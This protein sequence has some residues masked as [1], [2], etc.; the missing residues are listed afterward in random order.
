MFSGILLSRLALDIY[1]SL[2]VDPSLRSERPFS[3]W[4]KSSLPALNDAFSCLLS[5]S[6]RS[7]V[8]DSYI[9]T[10]FLKFGGDPL[11]LF[12]ICLLMRLLLIS[13]SPSGGPSFIWDGDCCP[14]FRRPI[15]ESILLLK[16]FW[17]WFMPLLKSRI[18]LKDL[19]GG[20]T[21]REP[22]WF[23]SLAWLLC[24]FWIF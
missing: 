23:R 1:W 5:I 2:S 16:A 13:T 22:V 10:S 9:L 14:W 19:D 12:W 8:W 24:F 15:P 6:L 21:A 18:S 3:S 7:A 11:R 4:E 20:L 17:D